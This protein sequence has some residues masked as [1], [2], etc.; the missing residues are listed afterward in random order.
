MTARL[1]N[2]FNQ[3]VQVD[4]LFLGTHTCLHLLYSCIRWSVVEEIPSKS[5]EHVLEA[6]TLRW[7]GVYGA[8]DCFESDQEGALAGEAAGVW[9]ARWGTSRRL[10]PRGASAYM[11]ERHNEL[12]RQTWHRVHCQLIDENLRVDFKLELAEAVFAKNAMMSVDGT[13]P[14]HALL[15]RVPRMLVDF[16]KPLGASADDSEG[17]DGASK[18]VLRLR[19]VAL[20]KMIE[21]TAQSR[22]SRAL[23]SKTRPASERLELSTGDLV[24]Y[25]RPEANKDVSQWK[26]PAKVVDLSRQHEGDIVVDFQGRTISCR[27]QDVRR[28]LLHFV[29][30]STATPGSVVSPIHELMHLAESMNIGTWMH[31]GWELKRDG[32]RLTTETVRH[33][34]TYL[35][36]LHVAACGLRLV[37]CLSVRVAH[38]VQSLPGA[39]DCDES[40]AFWWHPSKREI[41]NAAMWPGTQRLD[42]RRELV[43]ID[44][45][46]NDWNKLCVVQFLVMDSGI[47]DDVQQTAPQIPHLGG[48]HLPGA[49]RI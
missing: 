19:E 6:I 9:A 47:V 44:P 8:P 24:D 21:A 5:T 14:Y 18:H 13:T 16:E 41:P 20:Q 49:E 15:G 30:P 26:G 25:R 2:Q 3:N 33:Y 22:M 10:R 4:L 27:T 29:F 12:I 42:V 31:L 46:W 11:V 40:H 35:A 7:C 39:H 23:N 43:G 48:L 32:W 1:H 38:G 28:A 17:V 37:G 34:D 45:P 36:A